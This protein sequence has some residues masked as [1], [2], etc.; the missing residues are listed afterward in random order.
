M[1]T[2][3]TIWVSAGIGL[4]AGAGFYWISV[5]VTLIVLVILFIPHLEPK[6]KDEDK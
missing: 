6:D 4:A 2:A 5:I 3:A 1:T